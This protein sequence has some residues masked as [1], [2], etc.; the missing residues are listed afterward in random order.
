MTAS[1]LIIPVQRWFTISGGAALAGGFVYTY[2]AGTLTPKATYTDFS[3]TTPHTNPIVLDSSGSASIW[4]DGN[5]KINVLDANGVQQ[6][7]WPQDNIASSSSAGSNNFAV[8]TGSA[9]SYIL[10]P[11]PAIVAY[12]AG[13]TFNVLINATN[14]GPSTINVSGLGAQAIRRNG[15]VPLS[16]G[17]MVQGSIY[18]IIY[19]GT[20]FQLQNPT[21]PIEITSG[22]EVTAPWGKLSMNGV[23]TIASGS[24]ATYSGAQYS[25]T[26]AYLWNNVNNTYAP[27]ATGRGVSAAADFAANK[28]ITIPNWADYSAYGVGSLLTSSGASGGAATVAAAGTNVVTM[29]PTTLTAGQIPSL[30]YTVSTSNVVNNQAGIAQGDNTTGPLSSGGLISTNAGGG[31]FTPTGSAAFTGSATSVVHPVRGIYWYISY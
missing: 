7:D 12:Q 11:T 26:Y 23:N 17:E 5:Y 6:P 9:N 20:N 1:P 31:S 13:T 16:G 30:S 10:T 4:L 19:D 18:E 14:T 22:Y 2:A 24:G 21:P 27:V 29:N 15:T 8:A 25:R 3:G 28:A